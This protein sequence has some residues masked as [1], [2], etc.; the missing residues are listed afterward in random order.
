[1]VKMIFLVHRRPDMDEESFHKYWSGTHANIA[2]KMPGLRRYIQ[3]HAAPEPDGSSPAYDGFA[4]MWWDDD[5]AL[6]KSLSSEEGKAT[7]ADTANFIDLERQVVFR[8]E[9]VNVVG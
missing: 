1:M 6:E 9:Q 5:A 2:R 4:E 3:H 7:L 8:V